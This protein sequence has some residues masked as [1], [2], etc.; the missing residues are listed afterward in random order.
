MSQEKLS[1]KCGMHHAYIGFLER[2]KHNPSVETIAA[3]LGITEAQLMER[4]A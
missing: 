1:L 3:A 2:Q 4:D